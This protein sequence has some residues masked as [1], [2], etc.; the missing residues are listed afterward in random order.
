MV[1]DSS[2]FQGISLE[3]GRFALF[4]NQRA[5]KRFRDEADFNG[6]PGSQVVHKKRFG[7]K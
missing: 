5:S 4:R 2:Q 1:S 3:E 6:S 7:I